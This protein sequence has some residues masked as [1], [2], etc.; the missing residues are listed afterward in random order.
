MKDYLRI[1]NSPVMYS[2]VVLL[3][4]IVCWQAWVYIRRSLKRAEELGIAKER[5]RKA[6]KVAAL[7]SIV[8][9]LAIVVALLTLVP[10]LGLPFSWGRLS[11]I[12]SLTYELFAADLGAKASGLTLGGPGYGASAFLTSVCTQTIGSFVMLFMTIFLFKWYKSRLNKSIKKE[13]NNDWG[14]VLMAALIVS[15]YSRFVAEPL[16]KGGVALVAMLGSA[17]IMILLGLLIKKLKIKWLSDFS[18][19]LSMIAGMCAAVIYSS[20][21][22]GA[23]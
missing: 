19:S 10:V 18:L 22:Q 11:I 5:L 13:G 2:G 4:G 1:A 14:R 8:P 9:S 16:V 7:T 3:L 20:L 23:R 21:L 12:G 17:V 15:M 6:A